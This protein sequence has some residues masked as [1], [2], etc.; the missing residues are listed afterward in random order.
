MCPQYR[1]KSRGGTAYC[2]LHTAYC[3]FAIAI[4]LPPA[5]CFL[6]PGRG[7]RRVRWYFILIFLTEIRKHVI[8][9]VRKRKAIS[10]EV[11]RIHH[12]DLHAYPGP[13]RQGS[14]NTFW[15]PIRKEASYCML[16]GFQITSG[17]KM[18]F[19]R[20][21]RGTKTYTRRLLAYYVY[22]WQREVLARKTINLVVSCTSW[23]RMFKI[24]YLSAPELRLHLSC[25]FGVSF[26]LRFRSL[27]RSGVRV[28]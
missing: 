20:N 19:G 11:C 12:D 18:R 23:L 26:L 14:P 21:V 2:L 7:G 22:N 15:I 5:S 24:Y 27:D 9:D 25:W 10:I 16:Y 13:W 6:P 1:V 3:F 4:A 17:H 28:F 8:F